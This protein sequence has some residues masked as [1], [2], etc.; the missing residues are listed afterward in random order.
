VELAVELY[1][2]VPGALLCVVPGGGHSPIY[3]AERDAFVARAL[4]FLAAPA[5]E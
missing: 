1:R 4:P 5:T 3:H 2:A